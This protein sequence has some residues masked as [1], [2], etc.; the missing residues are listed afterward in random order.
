MSKKVCKC[1]KQAIWKR[2]RKSDKHLEPY[3]CEECLMQTDSPS[4]TLD[5]YNYCGD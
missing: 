1:G 4:K 5:N 3:L 2:I